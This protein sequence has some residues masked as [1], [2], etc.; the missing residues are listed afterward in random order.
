MLRQQIKMAPASR[1]AS[2]CISRGYFDRKM[3]PHAD[4]L[5]IPLCS[6]NVCDRQR[7]VRPIKPQGNLTV[8]GQ[9]SVAPRAMQP[10]RLTRPSQPA[11]RLGRRTYCIN[12]R[13]TRD[14]RTECDARHKAP[15]RLSGGQVWMQ[16]EVGWRLF[17]GHIYAKIRIFPTGIIRAGGSRPP[18]A[19]S[20]PE[21]LKPESSQFCSPVRRLCTPARFKILC[22]RYCF[23]IQRL[24]DFRQQPLP[25]GGVASLAARLCNVPPPRASARAA[26]EQRKTQENPRRF[27]TF[28]A[29]S[30]LG[31]SRSTVDEQ[32]V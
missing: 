31:N 12:S 22:W 32:A 17:E 5:G 3:R 7:A 15:L 16:T 11:S 14:R 25:E 1:V 26:W 19:D 30:T 8:R 2:G 10:P 28:P 24:Y 9:V 29:K 6:S 27:A 13:L 23:G 18:L 21:K 20:T 4:T